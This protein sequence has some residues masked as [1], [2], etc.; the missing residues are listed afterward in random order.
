VLS[1]FLR[2][3]LNVTLVYSLFEQNGYVIH[4]W[5]YLQLQNDFLSTWLWKIHDAALVCYATVIPK[6]IYAPLSLSASTCFHLPLP[7]ELDIWGD[8]MR[9][10][11][12]APIF[13]RCHKPPLRILHIVYEPLFSH[14]K[15]IQSKSY[16]FQNNANIMCKCAKGSP[17]ATVLGP[18]FYFYLTGLPQTCGPYHKHNQ[19]TQHKKG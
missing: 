2:S 4:V 12:R 5:V 14:I 7:A 8:E 17:S 11:P 16:V 18:L 3:R 9:R 13:H 6:P 19:I 15:K 1:Y 10:S